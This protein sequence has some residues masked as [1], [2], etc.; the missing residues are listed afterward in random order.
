MINIAILVCLASF[1]GLIFGLSKSFKGKSLFAL[2]ILSLPFD[3]YRI[4][5]D[6]VN[7]SLFRF[8]LISTFVAFVANAL[9]QYRSNG[10]EQRTHLY[11]QKR[12][13]YALAFLSLAFVSLFL[14]VSVATDLR[15]TVPM[16]FTNSSGLV[17]TLLAIVIIQSKS[18]VLYFIRIFATTYSIY[19]LFFVYTYYEWYV[20]DSLITEVPFQDFF[21]YLNFVSE[22]E[23]TTVGG[24]PRLA[25][26]LT[27][28]PHTSLALAMV[29]FSWQGT[30][31]SA[32]GKSLHILQVA[33][34]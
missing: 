6:P 2:T 29:Y 18:D 16:L 30:R 8:L 10:V 4:P 13:L 25:L 20:N 23:V 15:Y 9:R 19:I 34:L 7:M 31:Y 3:L 32:I 26:P 27:Q 1:V 28:P 17:F 14:S 11:I 22:L 33:R 21:P 24:L 12:K 5:L